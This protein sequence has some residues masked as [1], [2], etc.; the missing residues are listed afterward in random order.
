MPIRYS[1]R[2]GRVLIAPDGSAAAVEVHFSQWTLNLSTE[3]FEVTQFDDANRVYVPGLPDYSGNFA[4]F[5]NSDEQTLF[6]A[7]AQDAPV[8]SYLYVDDTNLAGTYWYG[9]MY[10][11]ATIDVA[12]GAA[13]AISAS[14]SA[15]GSWG[16]K[17][18]A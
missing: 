14:F 8:R 5:F 4:G 1:G 6:L 12:V 9:L 2:K 15:G 13:V 10:V 17:W 16:Q 3:R 11:D 7:V 18:S